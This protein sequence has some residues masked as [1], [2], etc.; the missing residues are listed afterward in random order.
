MLR[1]CQ[2]MAKEK[3]GTESV[4]SEFYAIYSTNSASPKAI[5]IGIKTL[6]EAE[7]IIELV[8]AER[9]PVLV[10]V[11]TKAKTIRKVK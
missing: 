6:A 3:V 11:E 1:Q 2:E 7:S 9:Q 5:K 8:P 10:K 4:V